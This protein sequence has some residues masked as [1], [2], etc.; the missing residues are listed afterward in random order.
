MKL[1]IFGANGPTGRLL[2]D[3]ALASGH[4]VT[5]VTR[6]PEAFGMRHD[7]LQVVGADVHDA[8]AVDAALAGQDAVLSVLGVPYSRQP[9]TVYSEGTG[10]IMT[11]MRTHGVRRLVCVSASLTDPSLGP[12]GG[13]FV[14]KV[15]GPIVSYFGRTVYA[16]MARMEALVRASAL[17]WTIMRPNGLFETA[18]VTGYRLAEDYLDAAYTSRAD[19][20]AAM[21]HQLS[22]DAFLRKICAIGTVDEKPRLLALLLREGSSAKREGGPDADLA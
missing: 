4:E 5:A 7:R 8:D 15:A 16:D 17:D 9:V 13:F 22:S 3:Q 20:A 18:Q 10:N 19:L 1:I 14:D 2:T 6:R 12:H 21:L 11:A